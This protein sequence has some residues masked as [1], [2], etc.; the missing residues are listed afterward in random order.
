MKI[1]YHTG[2]VLFACLFLIFLYSCS[3]DSTDDIDTENDVVQEDDTTDDTDTENDDVQEDDVNDTDNNNEQE[4][5]NDPSN[6]EYLFMNASISGDDYE[7]MRPPLYPDI[8]ASDVY[9][10]LGDNSGMKI[11]HL[12]GFT[13]SIFG[14]SISIEIFIRSNEWEQGV[15]T[16]YPGRNNSEQC[17]VDL[18]IYNGSDINYYATEGGELSITNFDTANRLIEGTFK[19]PYASESESGTNEYDEWI[20]GTFEFPLDHAEFD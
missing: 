19:F 3:G 2:K 6:N 5:D 4:E 11:L 10:L 15:Y 17:S 13:G 7:G 16:L 12:H 18:S 9:T 1:F 20:S 8:T 14:N